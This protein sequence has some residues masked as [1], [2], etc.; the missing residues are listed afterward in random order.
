MNNDAR[1]CQKNKKSRKI[2]EKQREIKKRQMRESAWETRERK[3]EQSK[4]VCTLITDVGDNDKR[5]KDSIQREPS[6]HHHG[7]QPRLP[8]SIPR[9]VL[10]PGLLC[11]ENF[12][13]P[14]LFPSSAPSLFIPLKS[15]FA[16]TL[17]LCRA[18]EEG[19]GQIQ[20]V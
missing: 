2:E 11:L 15:P 10:T 13:T 17:S 18:V 4:S 19:F 7:R 5:E 8:S 16:S 3:I 20:T 12:D 9:L 1:L 14:F 6:L